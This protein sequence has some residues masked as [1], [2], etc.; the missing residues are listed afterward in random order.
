MYPTFFRLHPSTT[1]PSS[2]I[3]LILALALALPSLC[4]AQMT[5]AATNQQCASS[6][7]PPASAYL[8]EIEADG[9]DLRVRIAWEDD[10][11]LPATARIRVRDADGVVV[12]RRVVRPAPGEIT[13]RRIRRVLDEVT[14]RGLG[15]T[16]E[17]SGGLMAP[18]PFRAELRCD[19][20]IPDCEWTIADGVSSGAAAVGPALAPVLA[21]VIKGGSS[22][23]LGDVLTQA[24]QLLGEV[25]TLAIDLERLD[26]RVGIPTG[27]TSCSCLWTDTA[28]R[29][30]ARRETF[31]DYSPPPE[32]IE[33]SGY[34]GPGA[35]H[36]A[37]VQAM[38]GNL[39]REVGGYESLALAMECWR[40]LSWQDVTVPLPGTT[41]EQVPIP[42]VTVCPATCGGTVRHELLYEARLEAQGVTLGMT[43]PPTPPGPSTCP[44]PLGA[45]ATASEW[46][47]Y[48]VDTLP[49][50][51]EE[52]AVQSVQ[53]PPA[54]DRIEVDCL[55]KASLMTRPA[56]SV[57]RLDTWG[58]AEV[59]TRPGA[60]AF[61]EVRN[62]Y[63]LEATGEA[64]C[65]LEAQVQ[66]RTFDLL[67]LAHP[68][69]PDGVHAQPWCRE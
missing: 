5:T 57:A 22:D 2:S 52:T 34:D 50:V 37:G 11:T 1:P 27:P 21:S 14:D 26:D 66:V 32:E 19:P 61:A 43:S 51:I 33:E 30:P 29:V 55:Q 54:A 68:T 13:R 28:D 10:P 65:T 17:V 36:S 44:A 9:V 4:A 20:I 42:E 15:Y 7:A 58:L 6:L 3:S 24:P 56:P 53:L 41:G 23:I 39:D 38:G 64:S 35:A 69:S 46:L 47:A 31:Y 60:F 62:R 48:T 40:F 16:I 63:R 18:H 59:E 67:S 45:C 25:V 49:A 12:G 8:A